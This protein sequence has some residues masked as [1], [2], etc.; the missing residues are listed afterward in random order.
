V[1]STLIQHHINVSTRPAVQTSN[2]PVE[3][4]AEIED[5]DQVEFFF[6]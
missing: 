6:E 2:D 3:V 1:A 5:A 4:V